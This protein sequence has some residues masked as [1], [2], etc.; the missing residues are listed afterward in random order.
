MAINV[1]QFKF[2]WRGQWQSGQLYSKNDIVQYNNAAY[3]CLQNTPDEWKIAQ[4]KTINTITN[5]IGEPEIYF[6]DK[7]PDVESQYWKLIVRGNTF[8]RGWMPHRTYTYGDIVR[9]GGDLYMYYG[10]TGS[11]AT[12]TANV[13]GQGQVVSISV[14]NGGT[15]YNVPPQITIGFD[16]TRQAFGAQAV[17]VVSNGTVTGINVTHPGSGYTSVPTVFINFTPVRNT[18]PED[19]TYWIRVFQNPA[20]DTRRLYGVATA[21]QQPLG[22][23][24]NNGDWP[25]PQTNDGNSIG[26]IGADGVPYSNGW[27]AGNYNTAGR[28]V[29][30]WVN[31]WQPSTFTFVD[32]L[33][34]TDMVPSLGLTTQN[35]AYLPTPDG[36][37][38]R[39]IQW[40]RNQWNSV[41]LFNNG[42]VYSAGYCDNRGYQTGT[43]DT[44]T[45][46]WTSRV[47]NNSTTGWLNEALPRS[48]N[49]TKM[50]K[51]DSTT[52]GTCGPNLNAGY[53]WQGSNVSFSDNSSAS[54]YT[55]G[56]DGSI[57]AWGYNAYGQL[58]LGQQVPGT[59]TTAFVTQ[60]QPVRIPASHFD[61]K[62]VVDVMAF[63]AN[64]G[65]VLAL[66]EDGDLW[67]WGSDYS[68]E[69]GL[70][71]G[72]PI[73][74]GVTSTQSTTTV[75]LTIP[76][77]PTGV[78]PFTT[79]QTIMVSGS[80]QAIQNGIFV[81]TGTTATTITYT[82]STGSTAGSGIIVTGVV[83]PRAIPTRIAFDFKK[84]GGVKKMAY[85]QYN[86]QYNERFVVILTNDGSMFGAGAFPQN[87]S[88]QTPVYVGSANQ[89]TIVNRFTKFTTT[90]G[91]TGAKQVD[92]FW[93]VGDTHAPNIFIREKDTGL[94][95]GAGD[96]LYYT[97]SATNTNYSSVGTGGGMGPWSLIKG[98]RN[99]VAVTM[100]EAGSSSQATSQ[101]SFITV[102]MLDENGRAWGQGRNYQGSLSLGFSGNSYDNQQQNPETGGWYNYQPVKMPSNTRIATIM[103]FGHALP[104]QGSTQGYDLS[105]FITDDGQVLY[106]GSDGT[107]QTVNVGSVQGSLGAEWNNKINGA[108]ATTN[109]NNRYTMHSLVSD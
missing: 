109:N 87:L 25:N 16:S 28:G 62:K 74:T 64:F 19:A 78:N 14:T 24:R 73:I 12:A 71:G 7:R 53:Q 27:N 102:L 75:T 30:Y 58:G 99:I 41:W 13:N 9:Y 89:I 88:P 83:T 43:T 96:N 21:N 32:W 63:G 97:I 15:G 69:L 92:N 80:N 81:I 100:T 51:V 72:G 91:L 36:A 59:G 54:W 5:Y 1:S 82:T 8:K 98:P 79:G 61:Y 2:N 85:C 48:F 104:G 3:V 22:W 103:G 47:T 40:L 45:R 38:P 34:S 56:Y 55:L 11:G 35:A 50:I 90:G 66:D 17:A 33:R 93:I 94:T 86:G 60:T 95:Y 10:V 105:A 29:R 49:Q 106:C 57:W 67:G 76:A 46:T 101:Y 18:C 31:S 52:L 20:R 6:V 23:T 108:S 42:E 77:Q 26:W 84:F 107:N 39:C 65:S 44:T 4:E 37:T 70:G 68:G